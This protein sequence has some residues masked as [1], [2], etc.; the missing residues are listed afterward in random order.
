MKCL[1]QCPI[2][3]L[4]RSQESTAK[5]TKKLPL[6]RRNSNWSGCQEFDQMTMSRGNVDMNGKKSKSS[7][8]PQNLNI[9]IEKDF[10]LT[11]KIYELFFRY[12]CKY[13]LLHFSD[14]NNKQISYEYFLQIFSYLLN[15]PVVAVQGGVMPRPRAVLGTQRI[16]NISA[17]SSNTNLSP[18]EL[19]PTLSSLL[20]AIIANCEAQR[21]NVSAQLFYFGW[22]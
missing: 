1:T 19:S 17:S 20:L 11:V 3:P 5:R 7:S 4:Q 6:S 15:L 13:G 12:L 14:N 21:P 10:G 8:T 22:C 9:E 18:A 16:I 2:I